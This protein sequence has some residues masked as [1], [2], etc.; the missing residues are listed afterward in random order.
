MY[1][2]DIVIGAT[3]AKLFVEFM[4]DQMKIT[5]LRSRPDVIDA[6]RFCRA[7]PLAIIDQKD[8]E[9]LVFH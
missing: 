2:S 3:T 8:D 9:V 6:A 5:L 1:P 4:L 7:Y